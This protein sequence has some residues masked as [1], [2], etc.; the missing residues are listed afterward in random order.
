MGSEMCIRDSNYSTKEFIETAFP[1]HT[2]EPA[3]TESR[4]RPDSDHI[5]LLIRGED[6]RTARAIRLGTCCSPVPGDRILGV[7][8][9]G[10]GLV[11][12]TIDCP[13]LVDW[14]QM[15][16]RWVDLKW[17]RLAKTDAMATGRI[18]VLAA[19]QRGVLAKLC[20]AVASAN[21]NITG[22]QT[23]ERRDDF[24]DL[25][26]EIEVEDLKRLTEILTALRSMSVVDSAERYRESDT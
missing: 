13:R 9:P 12:H 2:S 8:E 20:Q 22:L 11:V 6:L 7:S 18:T 14:D 23:G 5:S 25:V 15:P 10:Q 21:G 24:I 16:D 4:M 17:T 1:G 26:F 3:Q 19:N